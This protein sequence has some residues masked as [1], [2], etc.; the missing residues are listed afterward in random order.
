MGPR[1]PPRPPSTISDFFLQPL[2]LPA[3]PKIKK[4][5]PARVLNRKRDI[6]DTILHA[7]RAARHNTTK[8]T[9]FPLSWSARVLL[10]WN[11]ELVCVGQYSCSSQLGTPMLNTSVCTVRLLHAKSVRFRALRWWS[12]DWRN[13]DRVIDKSLASLRGGVLTC[14]WFRRTIV[15]SGY[16]MS[17]RRALFFKNTSSQ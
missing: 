1:T 16:D 4:S 3:C 6:V 17:S 7:H 14:R 12:V 9:S 8:Q 5:A 2:L 15:V 13:L 10:T 11:T